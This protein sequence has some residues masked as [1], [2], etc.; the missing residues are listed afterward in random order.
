M[1]YELQGYMVADEKDEGVYLSIRE[2]LEVNEVL[3]L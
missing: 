2:K 1:L 3:G